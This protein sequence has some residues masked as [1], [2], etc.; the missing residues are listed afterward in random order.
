MPDKSQGFQEKGR[1][2]EESSQVSLVSDITAISS[3]GK[4]KTSGGN[5]L[6]LK[7]F[8]PIKDNKHRSTQSSDVNVLQSGLADSKAPIEVGVVK[9]LQATE[10]LKATSLSNGTA[11][12]L[13]ATDH[14]TSAS[15]SS[16]HP[17]TDN[18]T[19]SQANS[20][21]DYSSSKSSPGYS[22]TSFSTDLCNERLSQLD[23]SSFEK[24]NHVSSL[25]FSEP[26]L[27]ASDNRNVIIRNDPDYD[28]GVST[29]NLSDSS[30][31]TPDFTNKVHQTRDS[32][33]VRWE[34]ED[35]D[36]DQKST[37]SRRTVKEG[38]CC[39][40]QAFHRAFL[41]CVEETPAML[42]GLVLS[43]AFCVAIIV[44]IPTTGRVRRVCVCAC[45]FA[46][47]CVHNSPI[48]SVF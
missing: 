40:Y 4:G 34:N 3:D 46:Y 19:S 41:Q 45:V 42:S 15:S 11:V 37:L 1:Q 28:R 17:Q 24:M 33:D 47:V 7:D 23:R 25:N 27:E 22:C 20:D 35:D 30:S 43:L 16:D 9:T 10:P 13:Q 21:S 36:E 48:Y 44:L 14:D 32:I 18:S 39:C 6:E 26:S 5:I 2:G 8:T 31:V 12:I 29:T 38:M